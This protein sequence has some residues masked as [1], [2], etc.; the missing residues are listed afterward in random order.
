VNTE[1]KL[2]V[3]LAED[4]AVVRSGLRAVI[5]A[6]DDMEVVAEAEDG[7]SAVEKVREVE[8]DVILMDITMPGLGGLEATRQIKQALPGVKIIV[9]TIHASEEFLFHALKVGADGYLTKSVHEMEVVFAIRAVSKGRCYIDPGVMRP[10]VSAF[11]ETS[12]QAGDGDGYSGLTEREKEMLPLIAGGQT[13]KEIA[14]ALQL[15]EHTVH[16]HRAHLMEKLGMHD[17][18]QLLMYAIRHG[19]ISP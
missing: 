1:K 6:Q 15:S 10:L 8:P 2:R 5:N 18:T 13:N 7:V 12:Q 14:E 11:V 19:I 4:H 3:M 17:R 9:L 16:N